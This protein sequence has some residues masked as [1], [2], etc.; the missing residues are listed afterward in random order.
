[1]KAI[2]TVY[3]GYRFRSRLEARWAVFFG[4]LGIEYQYEPEG[5]DLGEAGWYLPDFWLPEIKCWV[6]IKGACPDDEEILKAT[7]LC[8]ETK[9]HVIILQG[10]PGKEDI[11]FFECF[12]Y[13]KLND[14]Y[15][16]GDVLDNWID[17]NG[18]AFPLLDY[19]GG[20]AMGRLGKCWDCGKTGFEIMNARTEQV[21]ESHFACK[22]NLGIAPDMTEWALTAARQARFEHG[23]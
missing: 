4:T 5:F 16:G 3:N 19:E 15:P 10:I 1:M 2:E 21:L 17:D 22:H 12:E 11:N 6:E 23:G 18:C 8:L 13:Q 7:K 20:W 14:G 9:Q